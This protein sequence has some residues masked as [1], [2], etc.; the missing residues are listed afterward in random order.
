M[1]KFLYPMA[2]LLAGSGFTPAVAQQPAAETLFRNVRV[3][4]GKGNSLSAPTAVL[5]R[6]NQI[7]AIGAGATPR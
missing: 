6:G 4:D 3:F 7:A 2:A 1:K 5:V